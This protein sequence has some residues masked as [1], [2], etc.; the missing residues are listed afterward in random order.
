MIAGYKRWAE[1]RDAVYFSEVQKKA[2]EESGGVLVLC[3]LA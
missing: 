1:D 3:A 2:F